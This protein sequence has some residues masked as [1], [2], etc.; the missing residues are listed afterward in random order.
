MF[1]LS[2]FENSRQP[3]K[4]L[5]IGN[6]PGRAQK[7]RQSLP[8]FFYFLMVLNQQIHHADNQLLAI[9]QQRKQ[10]PL[11]IQMVQA[12]GVEIIAVHGDAAVCQR[13]LHFPGDDII[14]QL[15]QLLTLGEQALMIDAQYS[16]AI[17]KIAGGVGESNNLEENC[18][19]L[20]SLL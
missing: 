2:F 4:F 7:S 5:A 16:Q 13:F 12:V 8:V 1:P 9:E 6:V 3:L 19:Q 15:Q 20:A 14:G 11:L 10:P 18:R 17:G